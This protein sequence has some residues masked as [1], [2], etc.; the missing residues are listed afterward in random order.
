MENQCIFPEQ[1]RARS[2]IYFLDLKSYENQ[3]T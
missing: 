2:N 3:M 1:F